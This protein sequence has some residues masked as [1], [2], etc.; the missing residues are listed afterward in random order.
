[1]AVYPWMAP[2]RALVQ[3]LE[4]TFGRGIVAPLVPPTSPE[5]LPEL[6]ALLPTGLPA[7]EQIL[8]RAG[9]PRG[10]MVEIFGA[11]GVG[12]TSL[13]LALTAAAQRAGLATAYLDVERGL[14]LDYARALGVEPAQAL[15]SRPDCAET[16][17]QLVEALV[18]SG[19]VGLVVVDSLAAM[20]PR[21][22]LSRPL[23][24]DPGADQARLMSRA[25]RRLAAVVHESGATVVFVNQARRELGDHGQTVEVSGGGTALRYYASL[26][27]ELRHDSALHEGD[28]RVGDV[29]RV[30][31]C[32]SRFAM[33]HQVA[34]LPLRWGK[35]FV[36]APAS[37]EVTRCA[38]GPTDVVAVDAAGLELVHPTMQPCLV[39]PE[40]LSADGLPQVC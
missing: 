27:L 32:K 2:L 40:L 20:V 1:M 23:D 18:R 12:K 15:L 7:L 13:A 26:R 22:E 16:A 9:L 28:L 31:V 11:D 8:G 10:T 4:R 37:P 5:G 38:E 35:G 14:Q 25:L 36:A 34:L 17:W 21:A 30:E 33:P 39:A 3:S 6:P 19:G 24:Q 29:V